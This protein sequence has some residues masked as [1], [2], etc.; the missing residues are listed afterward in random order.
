[1]LNFEDHTPVSI[2]QLC[3]PG[4]VRL[5]ELPVTDDLPF[6]VHEGVHIGPLLLA[7]VLFR[8]GFC[9]SIDPVQWCAVA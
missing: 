7:Q 8:D 6:L 2:A 3:K 4:E 1:M 5:F 9:Q